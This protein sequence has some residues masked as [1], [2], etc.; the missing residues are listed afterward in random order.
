MS[1]RVELEQLVTDL[2]KVEDFTTQQ[3]ISIVKS[4]LTAAGTGQDIRTLNG[5][6][7]QYYL[8]LEKRLAQEGRENPN[9]FSD[10]W[11]FYQYWTD[12]QMT[13][14]ASRRVY[15]AKL[16][17]ANSQ[18]KN[19]DIW[20]LLHPDIVSIAKDRF[21]SK[22]YADAVEACLKEINSR[23]KAIVRQ[24][25]NKEH[26][27]AD[28]MNVAFSP[29]SPILILDDLS[30]EDGRSIQVGYMQIFAGAMTGIRNPKAHGNIVLKPEEAIPMLFLANLMLTKI[31]NA[32]LNPDLD[33][34]KNA[35]GLIIEVSSVEVELLNELREVLESTPG[36]CDVFL[37]ISGKKRI[38]TKTKVNPNI[39]LMSTLKKVKGVEGVKVV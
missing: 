26:D 35:Q 32:Q 2:A 9:G 37:D 22:H 16:Y 15:V 8:E 34:Q 7:K 10:L 23:V 30:T 4:I 20:S 12:N 17:N 33:A 36:K 6:Y 24:V 21:H 29:K 3:L 11:E 5:V 18:S 13:T 27:G 38:K 25:A 28:L 19:F 14:Y 39:K 31:E 1:D